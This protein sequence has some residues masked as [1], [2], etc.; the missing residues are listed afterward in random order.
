MLWEEPST[1]HRSGKEQSER[2]AGRDASGAPGKKKE[3]SLQGRQI[4]HA[5]FHSDRICSGQDRASEVAPNV[6]KA[7][8]VV[9]NALNSRPPVFMG[10][11]I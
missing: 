9:F 5:R 11:Y 2:G 8:C 6:G 10:K 4:A 1:Q 7:E 3:N